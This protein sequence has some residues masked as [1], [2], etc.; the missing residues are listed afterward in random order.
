[1][2]SDYIKDRAKSI[3]V[4]KILIREERICETDWLVIA[5]EVKEYRVSIFTS[6]YR[7]WLT[8]N[9]SAFY[10]GNLCPHIYAAIILKDELLN[11]RN[12]N[13]TTD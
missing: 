11:D 10:F 9:C 6:Q 13:H 2:F 5:A 12:Q 4:S 7:S 8:C 3:E 1:M